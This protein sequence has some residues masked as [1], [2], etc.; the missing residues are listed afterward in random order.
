VLCFVDR[1]IL[2]AYATAVADLEALSARIDKDGLVIKVPALDRNGEPSGA[3]IIKAH[4]ALKWRQDLLTKVK[5]LASEIGVTPAA[6]SRVS[7]SSE[8]ENKDKPINPIL[9][10]RDRV[11]TA[12]D[13]FPA[14]PADPE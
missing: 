2:A 11:R 6:R 12:R 1:D 9:A 7:A 5:Q 13:T 10:L 4:P 3:M 8:S 14:T